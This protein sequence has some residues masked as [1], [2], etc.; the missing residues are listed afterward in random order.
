MEEKNVIRN[1]FPSF[2]N[3][4]LQSGYTSGGAVFAEKVIG[5]F[6]NLSEKTVFERGIANWME[7]MKT[8]TKNFGVAKHSSTKLPPIQTCIKKYEKNVYEL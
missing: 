2:N 8:V 4:K 7:K 3:F 1:G 6:G 5:T